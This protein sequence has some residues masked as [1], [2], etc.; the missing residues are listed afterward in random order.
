MNA[1]LSITAVSRQSLRRHLEDLAAAGRLQVHASAADVDQDVSAL[2]YRTY[3]E[4]NKACLFTNVTG[5]PDWEVASQLVMDRSMWAIALGLPESQV[6][7]TFAQRLRSL[8][9]PV[10]VDEASV[11]EVVAIGED[12]DLMKLP[13]MWTSDRDP[14]RYIASGMC[15]IKDPETGI[16]NMSV[17]RA[18]ILSRNTTGY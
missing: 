18:Q 13:A 9:P 15:I 6:V 8:V 12:V 3:V 17:H 10:M 14:G 2:S 7:D 11:Q 16:R 5:F 4:R 1:P